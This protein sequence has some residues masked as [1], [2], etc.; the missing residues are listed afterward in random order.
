ML[1]GLVRLYPHDRQDPD[2]NSAKLEVDGLRQK[3][4]ARVIERRM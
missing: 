1:P 3:L 2:N 4:V